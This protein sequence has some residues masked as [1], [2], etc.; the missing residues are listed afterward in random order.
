MKEEIIIKYIAVWPDLARV[1]GYDC[2]G[3]SSKSQAKKNAP[4]TAK[5]IPVEISTKELPK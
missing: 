3:Y 1:D 4:E 2:E 5:I